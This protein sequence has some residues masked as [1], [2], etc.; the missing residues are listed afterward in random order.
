VIVVL[1]S[2]WNVVA[3][4]AQR[5]ADC[6]PALRPYFPRLRQEHR[7]EAATR[8]L[9]KTGLQ[10]KTNR[11]DLPGT[12]HLIV[13]AGARLSSSLAFS[14]TANLIEAVSWCGCPNHSRL[15]DERLAM[16]KTR[17]VQ[18]VDRLM[19][20][21]WCIDTIDAGLDDAELSRYWRD[22]EEPLAFVAWFAEKYDLIRFEP[23]PFRSAPSK[24][25][26]PA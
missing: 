10:L 21:H 12:P 14:S 24:P 6:T 26:P 18:A 13:A 19:K 15:S 3:K 23:R 20:R 17:W 25:P 4:S 16:N 8:R 11:R 9:I 1:W 22:G 2:S 5:Y 7:A